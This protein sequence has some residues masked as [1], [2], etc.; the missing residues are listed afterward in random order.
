MSGFHDVRL[1][2]AI[3][4]GAVGGPERL[5]EITRLSSGREHRNT[6]WQHSRRRWDIGVGVQHLDD[7]QALIAFFEARRGRLH[8]FRF[9]DPLDHKSSPPSRPVTAEDQL[10]GT[11][12]GTR[13][14]FALCKH[15]ESGGQ[16]WC[17]PITR[18]IAETVE[19]ALD[20]TLTPVGLDVMTG[21]CTFA[22]PPAS[23]AVITAG[24]E[25]DCVVRFDTDRLD[26]ALDHVRA[27]QV[28]SIAL[29]E[30]GG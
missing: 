16:T 17:R 6:P 23:G 28:P 24:F 13:V 3:S 7:V 25:F 19:V 1:P 18:P 30:V 4:L 27:G 8:S 2:F 21:E 22:E 11:G 9:R 29:V 14:R 10:L 12:D 5:T 26:I 15:Y 20:G